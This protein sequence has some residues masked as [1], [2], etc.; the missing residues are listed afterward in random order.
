MLKTITPD[1]GKMD[2]AHAKKR[3]LWIDIAIGRAHV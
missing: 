3:I 2:I 1:A